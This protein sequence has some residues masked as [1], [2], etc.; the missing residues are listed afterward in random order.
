MITDP[1]L[2]SPLIPGVTNISDLPVGRMKRG[3]GFSWQYQLLG[4]SFHGLWVVSELA[5]PTLY[6]SNTTGGIESQWTYSLTDRGQDTDITLEIQFQPPE[7]LIKR[8]ALSLIEP[9]ADKLAEAYMASLK[10]FIESPVI[11]KQ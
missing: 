1:A 11:K 8:Y 2:I 4:L 10:Q 3:S 9:H 5:E 7:S 6:R